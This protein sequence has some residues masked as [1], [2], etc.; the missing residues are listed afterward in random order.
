MPAT[1]RRFAKHYLIV[2][3]LLVF[4]SYGAH[5][6]PRLRPV[7][8][9]NSV[10][11]THFSNLYKVDNGVYRSEQPDEEGVQDLQ[12]LGI[13]EILN[14]RE[15]HHDDGEV[16]KFHFILDRV[17]MNAGEVTQAQVVQALQ[18]IKNRKGPILIHCWHGSD[19]T[20]VTVAAYR[21]IFNNWTK[22][23]AL[24]EMIN[25]GYGYHASFYPNL[26]DLVKN[27]DVKKMRSELGLATNN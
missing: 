21:I 26:V 14:L 24:D 11:G 2:F 8:W 12:L 19:R 15:Y 27:L 23:Q 5:A 3:S 4:T 18:K 7:T 13:K 1:S 6:E 25:G 9:G 10:I 17:E 20:G 16:E 22:A